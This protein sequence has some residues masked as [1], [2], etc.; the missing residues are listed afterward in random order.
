MSDIEALLAEREG[1]LRRG[2]KGRVA[3]VDAELAKVNI[4]TD[5]TPAADGVLET[6]DGKPDKTRGRT[7]RQTAEG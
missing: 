1:Y 2:L 6:T 3:Q 5:D 7:R 4:A